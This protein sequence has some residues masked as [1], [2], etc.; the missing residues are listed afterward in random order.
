VVAGAGE[1]LGGKLL[2]RLRKSTRYYRDNRE[3]FIKDEGDEPQ[4]EIPYLLSCLHYRYSQ[5]HRWWH[6]LKQATTAGQQL[7]SK[8]DRH[9][10]ATGLPPPVAVVA[11]KQHEC[12]PYDA[13]YAAIQTGRAL[14]SWGRV[15]SEGVYRRQLSAYALAFYSHHKRMMSL[16]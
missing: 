8:R 9:T 4:Q 16:G 6:H 7:Q 13:V 14:T 2:Y 11:E 3:D 1:A 5:L 10:G 12:D 15:C